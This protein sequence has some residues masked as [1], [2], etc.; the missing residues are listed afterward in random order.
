MADQCVRLS[1]SGAHV[2]QAL[3]DLAKR[4][5][6]IFGTGAQ[7]AVIGRKVRSRPRCPSRKYKVCLGWRRGSSCRRE[8]VVGRTYSDG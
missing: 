3:K 5:T 6:D 7:E 8:G 4:R 1:L 2:D